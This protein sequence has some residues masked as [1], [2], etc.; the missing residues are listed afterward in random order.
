MAIV[1]ASFTRSRAKIK[2]TLRYIVHRP[3]REGERLTRTLFDWRGEPT[4]AEAYQCIDADKG[5][6]YFHLKMNFH[7][8]RE[9]KR[10][11]L[12]LR[13]ITR[14]TMAALE[15]RLNRQIRF[16]AVEHSD[17]TSLRH[18]HAIVIVKLGRGERIGREDWKLCR[19]TATEAAL[20]ERKALDLFRGHH[21]ALQRGLSANGEHGIFS[22]RSDSRFSGVMREQPRRGG[23][24]SPLKPTRP[25]PECGYKNP[26]VQLKGGHTYYCLTCGRVEEARPKLRLKQEYELGR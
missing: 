15:E 23:R 9:D 16:L 12:D 3:G 17:H 7:P 8:Q 4:K 1:K 18:I 19:E 21:R 26:M 24:R 2:A 20:V 14:Q 6:T 5:M 11:D 13:A 22:L 10:R 25:C